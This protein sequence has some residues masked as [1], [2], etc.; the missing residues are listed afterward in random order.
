MLAMSAIAVVS[1]AVLGQDPNAATSGTVAITERSLL[2]YIQSGGLVSYVMVLLSILAVGL[3]IANLIQLRRTAMAKPG[4][5]ATLERLVKERNL[6]L[7]IEFAGQRENDCFV[8]RI[9]RE[10]LIRATRSPFGML[11][12]KPAMEDVGGR[13]LDKLERVNH[14]IAILAAVGPMLGLLGTTMGMIGAFATIGGLEGAARSA[15][16]ASY[17]SLALVTTAEGLIIAVPCTIAYSLFKRH[18]DRL[19]WYCADVAES[20]V[21]PLHGAP[22]APPKP[23]APAP[24]PVARQA[25]P[26]NSGAASA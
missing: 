10:G 14:G 6:K 9:V 19:A 24:M 3:M 11:E 7:A 13:E 5:V 12:L 2:G 8:A 23:L 1:A 20:I 4:V 15:Q 18:A 21:A 25:A 26:V 17:M 22:A 16:L